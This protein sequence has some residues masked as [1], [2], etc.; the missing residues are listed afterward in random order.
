MTEYPDDEIRRID[1]LTVKSD[2]FANL[3][4]EY[5]S[6]KGSRFVVFQVPYEE[7]TS[8]RRGAAGGPQAIIQ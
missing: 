7:T 3:P 2:N 4:A 5:S 8:F 1:S 6:Y